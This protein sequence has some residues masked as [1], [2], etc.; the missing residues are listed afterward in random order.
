MTDAP[1]PVP[2]KAAKAYADA[3]AKAKPLRLQ[4]EELADKGQLDLSNA[5]QAKAHQELDRLERLLYTLR[6]GAR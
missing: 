3:L 4:L 5:D 6:K 1:S 2:D